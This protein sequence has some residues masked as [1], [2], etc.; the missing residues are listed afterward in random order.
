MS[1]HVRVPRARAHFYQQ[2]HQSEFEIL[3]DALVLTGGNQSEAARHLGISRTSFIGLWKRRQRDVRLIEPEPCAETAPLAWA[4]MRSRPTLV[5]TCWTRA[6]LMGAVKHPHLLML[7]VRY[8]RAMLHA[9]ALDARVGRAPIVNATPIPARP[10][11]CRQAE[12]GYA[13]LDLLPRSAYATT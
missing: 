4:V 11:R 9:H 8:D 7:H 1:K 13:P 2:M 3:R 10:D 12:G 6:D 5:V